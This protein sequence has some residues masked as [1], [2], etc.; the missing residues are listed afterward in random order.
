MDL[1]NSSYGGK[2]SVL[3][4]RKRVGKQEEEE[5]KKCSTPSKR[6]QPHWAPSGWRLEN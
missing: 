3:S 4:K 6:V 1:I 2:E 5:E